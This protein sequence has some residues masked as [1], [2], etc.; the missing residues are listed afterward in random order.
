MPL[1]GAT[2]VAVSEL[3]LLED[4]PWGLDAPIPTA[5]GLSELVSAG[6]DRHSAESL[7]VLELVQSSS[8]R[9]SVRLN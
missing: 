8:G 9:W 5:L 7:T 6:L 1:A 4:R 3:L 2:T